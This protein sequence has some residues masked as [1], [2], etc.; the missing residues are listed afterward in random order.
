MWAKQHQ[1]AMFLITA[2]LLTS[3]NGYTVAGLWSCYTHG[4][5]QQY[6]W[7]PPTRSISQ[8]WHPE[9]SQGQNQLRLKVLYNYI[10]YSSRNFPTIR[11]LGGNSIKLCH[12]HRFN[13]SCSILCPTLPFHWQVL[14]QTSMHIAATINFSSNSITYLPCVHLYNYIFPGL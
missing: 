14:I 1:W 5:T 11:L 10:K 3:Q 4:K 2:A 13:P 7:H 12:W 6:P 9:K 8:L